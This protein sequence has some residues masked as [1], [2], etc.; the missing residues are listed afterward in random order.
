MRDARSLLVLGVGNVYYGDEGAGVHLVHHLQ[1]KYAFPEHV[2]VVDGGVLG[3]DLLGL[4]AEYDEIVLVD[5]VSAP[6]GK[7]YRFD[8]DSVPDEVGYGKLSSHEWEVPDL[9]TAMELYGDLP[10]VTIVAIG[11]APLEFETGEVGV[12]LTEP[13]RGRMEALA[14]V[15]LNEVRRRGAEPIDLRPELTA[16][17]PLSAEEIVLGH[18]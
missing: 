1:R 6:V 3:W 8:R 9:L 10:N 4:M 7:I 15:V 13:V 11:V 5:A 2:A 14:T 18:A 12:T 16:G 17:R